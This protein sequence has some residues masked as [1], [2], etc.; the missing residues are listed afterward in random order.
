MSW[1]HW[2]LLGGSFLGNLVLGAIA[3]W[4]GRRSSEQESKLGKLVARLEASEAS[5]EAFVGQM[6]EVVGNLED[7]IGLLVDSNR[8]LMESNRHA[9]QT[10]KDVLSAPGVPP[11]LAG[12]WLRS[13]L[14]EGPA[15]AARRDEAGA[16]P[17]LT[18]APKREPRGGK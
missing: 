1:W 9:Y 2:L 14:E 12:D 8:A 4:R 5:M 7:R 3:W 13:V 16:V 11:H 17:P 18:P 15:T 10:I 6:K